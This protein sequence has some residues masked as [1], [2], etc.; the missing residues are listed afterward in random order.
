MQNIN[1]R[2]LLEKQSNSYEKKT[3][4][5]IKLEVLNGC[6]QGK[7]AVMY[8]RFLRN[9]GFDVMDTKNALTSTGSYDYDH[10]YSKIE[11]HRGN[12]EMAY[13]LSKL[14]GINDSLIIRKNDEN[15]MIDISLIIGKD[16]QNLISY[17]EV[18]R[19]YSRY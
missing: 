1:L 18:A 2:E 17:D 15:L 6:G 11:I 3:G 10:E 14:M 8:Q 12:I 5:K 16:F 7:I 4:H 9:E 13:F 19:H